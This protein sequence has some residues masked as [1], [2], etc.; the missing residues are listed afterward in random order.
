MDCLTGIVHHSTK[1]IGWHQTRHTYLIDIGDAIDIQLVEVSDIYENCLLDPPYPQTRFFEV[2]IDEFRKG[3]EKSSSLWHIVPVRAHRKPDWH[4]LRFRIRRGSWM[5]TERFRSVTPGG[6]AQWIYT[7]DF[8]LI[9]LASG[10]RYDAATLITI[11]EAKLKA[12]AQSIRD[13][14]RIPSEFENQQSCRDVLDTMFADGVDGAFR[15]TV[16][17]QHHASDF[18]GGERPGQSAAPEGFCAHHGKA[19]IPAGKA[20]VSGVHV[21]IDQIEDLRDL[22]W[23]SE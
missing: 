12:I 11:I 19:A 16:L 3:G 8:N 10:G 9:F 7:D 23:L 21:D 22:S 14:S 20:A 2:E 1:R 5:V 18:P 4:I 13:G 17:Y 15:D 6:E